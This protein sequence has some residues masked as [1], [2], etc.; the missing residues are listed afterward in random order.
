MVILETNDL[1]K[2][3]MGLTA[4]NSVNLRIHENE[5]FG[6]IGP[7]GS[8]KSTCFNLITG[9]LKPT[10]G[11]ITL[12]GTPIAGLEPYEVAGNGIIKTFQLISLFPSLTCEENV[13]SGMHLKAESNLWGSIIRSKRYR[14]SESRL[15]D[16]ALELLN[17]LGLEER[18]DTAANKLPLG[19][20]RKLEIAIALAGE[21]KVLLLDEPAAGMSP[22]ESSDLLSLVQRIHQMQIT[23][24]VVEHNMRVVMDL[25]NRIAV[26]NYGVKIAEGTPDKIANDQEVISVYLG[27]KDDDA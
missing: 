3:F 25:C 14:R 2:N 7:N 4:L 10:S 8:G 21:P 16:K 26:L 6:L 27:N 12:K 15:R 5:I 13:V 23:I 17:F 9:F 22:K 19:E 24:L 11:S 18:R 1:T 20:E